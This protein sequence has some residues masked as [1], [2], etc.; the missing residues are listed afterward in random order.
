MKHGICKLCRRESD[1]CNSHLLPKAIFPIIQNGD[2][3]GRIS[4]V[5]DNISRFPRGNGAVSRPMLCHEYEEKFSRYEKKV[6]SYCLGNEK[7]KLLAQH[8]KQQEGVFVGKG[9]D[10]IFYL[11]EG[12][13]SIWCAHDFYYFALSILWRNSVM[14][15]GDSSVDHYYH[16][17]GE[18]Y[19]R[20]IQD[21]LL[22]DDKISVDDVYLICAFNNGILNAPVAY[23]PSYQRI[24]GTYR[25]HEFAIPG[26]RF[27]VIIGKK[28]SPVLE[29]MFAT[30]NVALVG[31]NLRGT[32]HEKN[33]FETNGDSY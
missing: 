9:I 25:N 8:L 7:H 10:G 23:F 1:I 13:L 3:T 21:Y 2:A 28:L 17:L 19:E 14:K 26:I 27:M 31:C 20:R 18:L 22:T 6:V 16:A 11:P 33:A 32:E 12:Y 30:S 24:D 4:V 29:T 5:S 15:W